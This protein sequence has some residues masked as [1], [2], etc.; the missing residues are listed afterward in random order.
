MASGKAIAKK[1]GTATTKNTT[2]LL[3]R[4]RS[5]VTT[6][7]SLPTESPT[8]GQCHRGDS[9]TIRGRPGS[10]GT[11]VPSLT[12]TVSCLSCSG[13]VMGLTTPRLLS[14]QPSHTTCGLR[15]R[16]DRIQPSHAAVATRPDA[17]AISGYADGSRVS[18]TALARCHRTMRPLR[19]CSSRLWCSPDKGT[20]LTPSWVQLATAA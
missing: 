10:Q 4:E 2:G 20:L 15:D 18:A 9:S 3:P 11:R 16:V 7:G 19:S 14:P 5:M 6:R 17:A 13:V 12:G 8:S 1:A